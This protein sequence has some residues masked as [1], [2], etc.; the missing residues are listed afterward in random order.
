MAGGAQ[1]IAVRFADDT[2]TVSHWQLYTVAL[3]IIVVVCVGLDHKSH[4]G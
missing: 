3:R 4:C 1:L 2:S